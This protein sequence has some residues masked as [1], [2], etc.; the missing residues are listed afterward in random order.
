MCAARVNGVKAKLLI[1]TGASNSCL[2]QALRDRFLVKELGDPFEA[3][4]ASEGKMKAVFSHAG[5]LHLGRF[6]T[7]PHSFVLLDMTHINATLSS[8]GAAPIDG[9]LG[10]DFFFQKNAQIDYQQRWLVF[11]RKAQ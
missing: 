5:E 11:D 7:G 9:I 1:D 6:A 2:N 4:G 3:A 8:Q 10:A